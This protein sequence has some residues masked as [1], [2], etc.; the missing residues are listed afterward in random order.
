[1]AISN[2]RV[3]WLISLWSAIYINQAYADLVE[4]LDP[5][6]KTFAVCNY[7]QIKNQQLNGNFSLNSE[8]LVELG[9]EPNS[10]NKRILNHQINASASPSELAQKLEN[11]SNCE[12][13]KRNFFLDS[14]SLCKR[15]LPQS[16][17]DE[18]AL[19]VNM[20]NSMDIEDVY[21]AYVHPSLSTPMSYLGHN[22]LVLKKKGTWNFSKVFGF[23]A[24]IPQDITFSKLLLNGAL[25]NLQGKFTYAN[26]FEFLRQYN[27][28][29]QRDIELFKINLSEADKLDLISRTI[30]VH[31]K[32]SNYNYFSSN[33]SSE[34]VKFAFHKQSDIDKEVQYKQPKLY[35]DK[36]IEKKLIQERSIR[37]SSG[38]SRSFNIYSRF[39]TEEKNKVNKI[40]NSDEWSDVNSYLLTEEQTKFLSEMTTISFLHDKNPIDNYHIIKNLELADERDFSID[41]EPKESYPPNSLNFSQRSQNDNR[42]TVIRYSPGFI[43][44]NES[45]WSSN[46]ESTLKLLEFVFTSS[47]GQDDKFLFER[48]DLVRLESYRKSFSI[49]NPASWVFE[50]SIRDP[51]KRPAL[52]MNMGYGFSVGTLN[53]MYSFIP[54][55]GCELNYG[56]C[57]A[58]IDNSLSYWFDR[59]NVSI[60]YRTK[61]DFSSG[62]MY[63]KKFIIF[64]YP[65]KS[66]SLIWVNSLDKEMMEIGLQWRF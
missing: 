62:D 42:A 48:L 45:N 54:S 49:Y 59:I 17:N 34:V 46:S 10:Q 5:K 57:V 16:G 25:G 35:I 11:L 12:A 60:N 27:D 23:S 8:I 63:G 20:V 40:L 30:S 41:V 53:T 37:F 18:C 21:L 2:P 14:K 15:V 36:L 31:D 66:T 47:E 7:Y 9:C 44:R 19:L 24:I 6:V 13:G 29:E 50:I 28:V 58:Y 22:F 38:L 51:E 4:E 26:F 33:C 3:F 56:S 64:R 32:I 43:E 1:M 65:L 39:S 61:N 52:L 55:L